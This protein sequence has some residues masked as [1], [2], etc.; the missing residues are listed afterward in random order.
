MPFPFKEFPK[1]EKKEEKKEEEY[2]SDKFPIEGEGEPPKEIKDKVIVYIGEDGKPYWILHPD[3]INPNKEENKELIE[4]ARKILR[5]AE[6][7]PLG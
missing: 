1:R 4:K 7:W 5:E 2:L 3:E 6:I